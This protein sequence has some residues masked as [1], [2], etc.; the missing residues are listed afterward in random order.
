MGAA[1]T[2]PHDSDDGDEVRRARRDRGEARHR[3]ADERC[4]ATGHHGERLAERRLLAAVARRLVQAGKIDEHADDM[5]AERV[6]QEVQQ[7]GERC[8]VGVGVRGRSPGVCE[9][10]HVPVARRAAR[11][12]RRRASGKSVR[13]PRARAPRCS[14]GARERTARRRAGRGR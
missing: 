1:H 5:R 13:R 11:R 6:A 2:R 12:P 8:A 10:A 7:R 4:I 3:R 9:E 14:A